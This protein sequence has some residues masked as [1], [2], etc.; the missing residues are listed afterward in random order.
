MKRFYKEVSLGFDENNNFTILLDERP[1]KTPSGKLLSTPNKV[2]AEAMHHEWSI[3]KDI[4]NP[5]IM[6][7]TQ[8]TTTHMDHV[9]VYRSD[10]EKQIL[11]YLDTDM[12]CYHAEDAGLTSAMAKRQASKWNKWIEWYNRK[13]GTILK[14]TT[15]LN[16][17]EQDAVANEYAK[18]RVEGMD[19]FQFTLL[20]ILTSETGSFI[21]ALAFM[22]EDIS[23]KDILETANV[24][25]FLKSEIYNTDFYG[26][27]PHLEKQWVEAERLFAASRLCVDAIKSA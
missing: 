4:I 1:V 25:D 21:L 7:V 5:Q 11:N 26:Q 20:Q 3:Q 19:D 27:D 12:L 22:D 16:A 23:P 15:E 8:I 24:E 18:K 10:I 14:T 9:S 13:S 17:I 2:I 6:P